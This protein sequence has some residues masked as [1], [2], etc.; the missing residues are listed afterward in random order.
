MLGDRIKLVRKNS[1]LTQD[2]FAEALS[3]TRPMIASYELRKVTPND[4]FIKHL[5]SSFNINEE[6]LRTGEGE[7]FI[8]SKE[9][10]ADIVND[11]MERGNEQIRD[12]IIEAHELSDEEL[13]TFLNLIRLM[14]AKKKGNSN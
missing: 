11:A 13:E 10:Y 14:N 9:L 4:V 1:N 2:K 7:M 8:S 12:L 6:W 5:C 3:V